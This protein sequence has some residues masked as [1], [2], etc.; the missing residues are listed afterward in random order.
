MT[1]AETLPLVWPLSFVLIAL[2]ILRKADAVLHPIIV[3]VIGGVANNATQNSLVY[4]MAFMLAVL[5][6]LQAAGEVAVQFHFLWLAA[7]TKILTPMLATLV[8][9]FTKPPTLAPGPRGTIPP[10][11]IEPPKP[12]TL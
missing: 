9:A 1:F 10:F 3:N 5:S 2:F 7:I 8:A 6:G 12:T 4:A 11:P